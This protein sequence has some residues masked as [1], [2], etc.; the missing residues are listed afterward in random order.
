MPIKVT[1]FN[2]MLFYNRVM[3][4]MCEAYHLTCSDVHHVMHVYDF[5]TGVIFVKF[6][7]TCI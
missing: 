1:L 6:I 4:A 2:D 7:Y 3:I 5:T